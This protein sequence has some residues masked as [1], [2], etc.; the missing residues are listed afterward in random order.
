[1]GL[2]FFTRTKAMSRKNKA[3]VG[4]MAT[5]LLRSGLR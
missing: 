3:G 2:N 5:P 4:R 1:V